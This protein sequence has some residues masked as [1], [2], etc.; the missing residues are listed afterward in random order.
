MQQEALDLTWVKA[1][2]FDVGNTLIATYPS[3][4]HIY[5]EIALRHGL[6]DVTPELLEARFRAIWPGRLH[7]TETRSG[8]AQLVDQ[9]FDGLAESPPSRTFFPEMYQRFAQ[10]SAWRIFDDVPPVLGKLAARGMRL[11]VISNWD[12][13][14][15]GLLEGL[16]LAS[17]FETIVVSCEV[18]HAKPERVVF[19]EAARRLGLPAHRILHIGDSVEMDFQ[20]ARAAGFHALE[21]RRSASEPGPHH[22]RSLL[23]LPGRLST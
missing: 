21:I 12:E 11:A 14:L 3:V 18:G 20:G 4:G 13:R 1:V 7:L 9:V 17:H 19:D 16:G 15:R 23:E 22:M 6:R 5:A 8:W 10:A 2:T